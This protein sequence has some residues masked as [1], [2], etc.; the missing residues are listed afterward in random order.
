MITLSI[1]LF[2]DLLLA[3]AALYVWIRY[4]RQ[5]RKYRKGGAIIYDFNPYK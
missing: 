3:I 2:T 4:K 5:G 1:V